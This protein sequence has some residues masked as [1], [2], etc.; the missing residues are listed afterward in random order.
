VH[1]RLSRGSLKSAEYYALFAALRSASERES[2]PSALGRSTLI[3]L[4]GRLVAPSPNLNGRSKK[5]S[6]PNRER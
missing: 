2:R 1:Q 4:N 6:T 5:R 3:P